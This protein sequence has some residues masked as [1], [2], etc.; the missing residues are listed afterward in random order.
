MDA[1]K[2]P[3]V[4]DDSTEMQFTD[5][6]IW[7]EKSSQLLTYATPHIVQLAPR[8]ANAKFSRLE[9]CQ[10]RGFRFANCQPHHQIK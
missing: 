4:Y 1:D 10:S 8:A 5:S 6:R 3:T 2:T 9:G 7:W